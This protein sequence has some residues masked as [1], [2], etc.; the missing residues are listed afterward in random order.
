MV[1]LRFEFDDEVGWPATCGAVS[2]PVPAPPRA[3]TVE[4][5]R[6]ART[7]LAVHASAGGGERATVFDYTIG[8]DAGAGEMRVV[9]TLTDSRG[10]IV[11]TLRNQSSDGHAEAGRV[12]WDGRDTFGTRVP[13]G[14][15]AAWLRAGGV[16][17][18]T[19]VVIDD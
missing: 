2:V 3:R 9:L 19:R 8:R 10:R 1:W 18:L 16:V 5:A 6:P 11:R 12:V 4:R 13:P 14:E 15:Y 17:R 7:T